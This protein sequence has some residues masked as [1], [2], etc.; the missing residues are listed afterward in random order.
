MSFVVPG[1]LPGIRP[2]A[3]SM[4]TLLRCE[5]RRAL[6]LSSFVRPGVIPGF[7]AEGI[8]SPCQLNEHPL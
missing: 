4:L 3:E 7:D 5:L 8:V 6:K 1:A 2:V